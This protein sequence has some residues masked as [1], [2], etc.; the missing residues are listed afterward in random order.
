MV[1]PPNDRLINYWRPPAVNFKED[2]STAMAIMEFA[3][4]DNSGMT[5]RSDLQQTIQ[6]VTRFQRN[7]GYTSGPIAELL[8]RI[9]N[10]LKGTLSGF[11]QVD[12]NGDGQIDY[13][14]KRNILGNEIQQTARTAGSQR[15]YETADLLGDPYAQWYISD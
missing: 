10:V 2:V 5:S 4:F 14:P 1:P 11:S 6:L 12:K 15:H 7:N 3:D 8:N 9:T 13:T